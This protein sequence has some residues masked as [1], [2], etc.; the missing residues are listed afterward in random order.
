M[1]FKPKG[2][3]LRLRSMKRKSYY[4]LLL[5]LFTF[6]KMHAQD[7]WYFVDDFPGLGRDDAATFT[8]GQYGY[9]GTGFAEGFQPTRDFFRFNMLSE[10][11]ETTAFLPL[12]KERQYASGFAYDTSGFLFGGLG[13]GQTYK[14]LW[15]YSSNHD[16]WTLIDSIPSFGRY[17]T[18][19]FVLGDKVYFVGG[20]N[21]QGITTDEVWCYHITTGTWTQKNPFPDSLWRASSAVASNLAFITMGSNGANN[22]LE[23]YSYD[24][25]N[26]VWSIETTFPMLEGLAYHQSQY[27]DGHIYVIFGMASDQTT[28]NQVWKYQ[29][30]LQNWSSHTVSNYAPR[31][32]GCSFTDGNNLFY[33]TGLDSNYQRLKQTLKH[34]QFIGIKEIQWNGQL[35][36]NPSSDFLTIPESLIGLDFVVIDLLGQ[37]VLSGKLESTMDV[38]RLMD[39]QYLLRFE[40]NGYSLSEIFTV[41]R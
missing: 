12:G 38:S 17:G 13:N 32:G 23:I 18:T 34:F 41:K 29:P 15:R 40:W 8:I 19:N 2:K 16:T 14:D 22:Y 9:V 26:D 25:F 33:T 36:P 35:Y 6:S 5:I 28:T 24:E 3:N 21:S 7:I 27:F 20:K 4:L 37:A 10:N 31:K 39:G 11:W 1:G 30:L